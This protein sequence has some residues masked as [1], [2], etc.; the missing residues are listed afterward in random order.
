MADIEYGQDS[1]ERRGQGVG[2]VILI[3]VITRNYVRETDPG[4]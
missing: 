1:W 2:S 4:A 3:F